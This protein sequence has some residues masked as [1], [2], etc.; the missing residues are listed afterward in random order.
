M[1]RVGKFR[2]SDQLC[3]SSTS[4]PSGSW[5]YV[6]PTQASI[7]FGTPPRGESICLTQLIFCGDTKGVCVPHILFLSI[8]HTP[9]EVRTNP[10]AKGV[11]KSVCVLAF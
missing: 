8:V 3:I 7:Y 1:L 2:F 9:G 11:E 5:L 6:S 4:F 10:D